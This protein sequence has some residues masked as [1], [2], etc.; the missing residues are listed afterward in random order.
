MKTREERALE[1]WLT[2]RDIMI[3][4]K[5]SRDVAARI[6]QSAHDRDEETKGRARMYYYGKKVSMESVCWATGKTYSSIITKIKN[7]ATPA[8]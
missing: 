5:V 1:E 7:G 2:K 4:F 3:V 6:F 8:K